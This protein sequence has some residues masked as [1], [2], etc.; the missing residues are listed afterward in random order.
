L[1]ALGPLRIASLWESIAIPEIRN[2]ALKLAE[3]LI[4]ELVEA[5]VLT[6]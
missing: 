6:N 2:Q 3:L 5:N 1:Y 4:S